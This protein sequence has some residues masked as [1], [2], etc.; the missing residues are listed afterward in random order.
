ML[1]S[2]P[3]IT[4]PIMRTFFIVSIFALVFFVL[5][6]GAE[7]GAAKIPQ[8]DSGS[9]MDAT[10]SI[11][12]A[13]LLKKMT[14]AS[15]SFNYQG[16][17][18]YLHKDNPNLQSFKVTHWLENGVEYE[19]LQ[20]LNGLDREVLRTGKALGCSSLGDE[21]LQGKLGKLGANVAQLDKFYK[22]EIR[23]PERIAGRMA[24]VLLALPLDQFRYSYFLSI[25]DETGLVLKSWLVDEAASPLERYQFIDLNLN[26]DPRQLKVLP[27]AKLSIAASPQLAECNPADVKEPSGWQLKWVPPGFA[28][29]AQRH[30]R[31][32]IDML[33]YTDG[34]TT[35]SVFIQQAEGASPQGVAQ[36][37]ATLAVMDALRYHDKNYR[38]TVVGE[39]PIVTAQKIA[40][41]LVGN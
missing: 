31:Q 20:H 26:P 15:H 2:L 6:V 36:R 10:E 12:V 28:F 17:F 35:F 25:D 21:L 22:F 27:P 4:E 11:R 41:N 39:I 23:G 18:T 9:A 8:V 38:V 1:L 3:S 40:Q 19:R 7:T 24:T 16:V 29:V 14:E 5:P 32:E 34:L 13:M 37:G 30:V 33:M